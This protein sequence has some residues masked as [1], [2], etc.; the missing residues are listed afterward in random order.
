MV[1]VI[2][3]LSDRKDHA[4]LRIMKFFFAGNELSL[5]YIIQGIV[6]IRLTFQENQC[7]NNE[8]ADTG[9]KE[10]TAI[11]IYLPQHEVGLS[12]ATG[13]RRGCN[14]MNSGHI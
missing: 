13:S 14:R 9:G 5:K 12:E 7:N 4:M 8:G 11:M 6:M 10:P 3:G 2:R 1:G